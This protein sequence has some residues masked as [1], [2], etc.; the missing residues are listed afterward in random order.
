MSGRHVGRRSAAAG[1]VAMLVL[2]ATAAGSAKAAELDGELLSSAAE[3][4]RLVAQDKAVWDS[5]KDAETGVGQVYWNEADA[6]GGIWDRTKEATAR[7]MAL[8]ATT[9]RGHQGESRCS[10]TDASGAPR[11]GTRRG[12]RRRGDRCRHVA[13]PR[14]AG[15]GFG[16]G[17]RAP[18]KAASK[19]S[20]CE[21]GRQI[22]ALTN[23]Y[24]AHDTKTLER[25]RPIRERRALEK[26]KSKLFCQ[27]EALV[28]LGL[29]MAPAT[30]PDVVAQLVL[31]DRRLDEIVACE[32]SAED[33]QKIVAAALHV[34]RASLPLLA[35]AAQIDLAA[36][37]GQG[38]VVMAGI[39]NAAAGGTS[40]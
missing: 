10:P 28:D 36:V 17:A 29:A 33:M 8:R 32:M 19:V 31:A 13:R 18:R 30:L 9:P 40:A 5:L 7:V 23:V 24:N 20:L 34:I 26:A 2:A 15:E 25:G 12:A 1:G 38:M 11:P 37:A 16:M 21:I 27:E 35:R 22:V 6:E 3:Y 39:E 4:H 14:P